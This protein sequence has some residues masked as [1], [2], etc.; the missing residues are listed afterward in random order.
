MLENFNRYASF[1]QYIVD[2]VNAKKISATHFSDL[3]R[4][5][6]LINHG[7]IWIDSAVL[8]TDREDEYLSYPL[9]VFQSFMQNQSAHASSNWFIVSERG[10]PILRTTRDLL[11]RYWLDHDQL[12]NYFI[13][14]ALFK[15]ATEKYPELWSAMPRFDNVS[16]HIL[17]FEFFNRYDPK[18]FEQIKRMSHFHK[19]TWKYPPE[20]LAPER[21]AGTNCEFV[22]NL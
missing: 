18:R 15:L 20:K 2:K 6:L 9:F 11:Q 14:H 5:E 4:L 21:I 12:V 7:G 10:N 19:L 16:P 8:S 3:L 1:P 22:L 13:F 17:Q